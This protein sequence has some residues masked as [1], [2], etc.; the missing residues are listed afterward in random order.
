MRLLISIILSFI[1]AC[2]SLQKKP[3]K[4]AA[5]TVITP[6]MVADSVG[7]DWSRYS[8]GIYLKNMALSPDNKSER[9][10]FLNKAVDSFKMALVSGK[11]LE[12]VYY[13]L[14]GCYYYL[15]NFEAAESFARK[16]IDIQKDF[17]P[18]YNRLFMIY[19][20]RNDPDRA[21]GVYEQYLAVSPD[22]YNIMYVL[23]EFYAKKLN[24]E[25]KAGAMYRKIVSLSKRKPVDNY[26]LE[27][28]YFSLGMTAYKNN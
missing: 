24:D 4:N 23:G 3:E 5:P 16:S 19:K 28:V 7:T 11:S 25:N 18:P 1:T 10:A 6:D 14:S 12:R 9:E 21:A 22:A 13:N 26:Y 27:N 8:Y 17:F 2:G 15:Q 20:I